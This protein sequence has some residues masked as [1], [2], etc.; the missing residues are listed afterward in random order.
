MVAETVNW[1]LV[2]IVAGVIAVVFM[3]ISGNYYWSAFGEVRPRLP[4][5]DD[6]WARQFLDRYIL[7]L[8][9]GTIGFAAFAAIV[10]M[11]APRP[12]AVLFAGLSI[13]GFV[14]VFIRWRKYR[15][16]L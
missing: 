12:P 13:Y 8:V 15:D 3:S 11:H 7:S 5:Q 9:F 10:W 4:F 6:R 14:H 1:G 2:T 16:L